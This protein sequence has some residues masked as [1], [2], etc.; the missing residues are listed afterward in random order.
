[1]KGHDLDVTRVGPVG[2]NLIAAIAEP[3]VSLA[4][5]LGRGGHLLGDLVVSP[6]RHP[7]SK[8]PLVVDE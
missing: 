5:G 8:P 2:I 7:R 1:M 4:L 6:L 3:V